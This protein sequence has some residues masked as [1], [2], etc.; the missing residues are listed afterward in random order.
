MTLGEIY[1]REVLELP[2]ADNEAVHIDNI[3]KLCERIADVSIIS[4]KLPG[5]NPNDMGFI[6]VFHDYSFLHLF[7]NGNARII[8]VRFGDIEEDPDSPLTKYEIH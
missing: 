5:V 8:E 3:R 1:G 2:V 4:D 6:C 7:F